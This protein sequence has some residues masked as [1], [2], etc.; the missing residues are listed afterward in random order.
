MARDAGNVSVSSGSAS[1]VVI[2]VTDIVYRVYVV[3]VSELPSVQVEGVPGT[4]RYICVTIIHDHQP[5]QLS[6]SVTLLH[7]SLQIPMLRSLVKCCC[8]TTVSW[9]TLSCACAV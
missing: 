3:A 5:L 9:I 4:L 1:Q 2:P 6:V 7:A 8:Q